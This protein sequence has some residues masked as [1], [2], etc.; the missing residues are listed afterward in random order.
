MRVGDCMDVLQQGQCRR[1]QKAVS[2]RVYQLT[3][4]KGATQALF[5]AI[6]S[7]IKERFN[8][9]SYKSIKSKDFQVALRFIENWN[10]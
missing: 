1:L 8:V 4:E 9:E 7:A 3:T 10:G 5:K 6:Y 2:A